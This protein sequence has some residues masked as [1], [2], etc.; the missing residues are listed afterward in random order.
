MKKGNSEYKEVVSQFEGL[1]DWMDIKELWTST[2][3]ARLSMWRSKTSGL[4][5]L[6][7]FDNFPFLTDTNSDELILEDFV[8]LYPNAID[9]FNKWKNGDYKRVLNE[10]RRFRDDCSKAIIYVIDQKEQESIYYS[11]KLISKI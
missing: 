1:E 6:D 8:H 3:T 4:S 9:S 2:R 11:F 10:S 5:T 7:I